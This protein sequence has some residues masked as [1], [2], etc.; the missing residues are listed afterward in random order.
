MLPSYYRFKATNEGS[1]ELRLT[2]AS[3]LDGSLTIVP[4]SF[5]TDLGAI[6]CF[7]CG[8]SRLITS[9]SLQLASVTPTLILISVAPDP[10]T[11]AAS[12]TATVSIDSIGAYG[13]S[14]G[15]VTVLD[16]SNNPVCTITLPAT[17]CTFAA[18]A[19]PGVPSTGSSL[20]TSG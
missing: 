12:I 18:P 7:N 3:P 16:T 6:E 4:L 10:T 13:P 5:L 14:T 17:S 1:R 20:I 2:P 15:T 8:P 19:T 11:P 9:G